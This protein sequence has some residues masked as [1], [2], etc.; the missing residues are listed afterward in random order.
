M[1][2]D[3]AEKSSRPIGDV[4][5]S[6]SVA[7]RKPHHLPV[8]APHP[9]VSSPVTYQLLLSAIQTFYSLLLCKLPYVIQR[10]LSEPMI[11]FYGWNR[12][13]RARS[14]VKVRAT[15]CACIRLHASAAS[16]NT[17]ACSAHYIFHTYYVL[18][19]ED[20]ILSGSGR[21]PKETV[22]FS[23]TSKPISML[24]FRRCKSQGISIYSHA[25]LAQI[26]GP[27]STSDVQSHCVSHAW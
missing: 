11:S 19:V 2:F 14:G 8:S 24:V 20:D 27:G 15:A 5:T 16:M 3:V 26:K 1:M 17:P 18:A 4:C 10:L 23:A 9:K 12:T 6:P 7:L 22:F 25:E 13:E 21:D